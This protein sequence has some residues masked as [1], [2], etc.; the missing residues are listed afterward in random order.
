MRFVVG[1][2]LVLHRNA[3][4]DTGRRQALVTEKLADRFEICSV[5]EQMR[6]KGMPQR[7]RA[8]LLANSAELIDLAKDKPDVLWRETFST[9]RNEQCVIAG[10]WPKREIPLEC[11]DRRLIYDDETFLSAF[12]MYLH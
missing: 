8:S 2:L 5:L 10:S 11:A 3:Q 12:P 7:V 9:R 6:R 1:S 4:I